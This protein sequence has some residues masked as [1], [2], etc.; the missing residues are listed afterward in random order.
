MSEQNVE[1]SEQEYTTSILQDTLIIGFVGGILFSLAAQLA[2][3]F[4]L[5]DFSPKFILT[6]WTNLSWVDGWLGIVMS[7][8]LFGLLSILA[9]IVYYALLKRV[10][11]IFAGLLYGGLLWLLLV[12]ILKPMFSDF[13]SY[14][15]MNTKTIITSVCIFIVYGVFVG[16]SISY[17]HQEIEKINNAKSDTDIT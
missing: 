17:E 16:Y 9:A 2:Y 1:K 4:N 10:Q 13:P 5:L 11:S 15:A 14:A 7:V 12:F 6:S 3:Y 8:L